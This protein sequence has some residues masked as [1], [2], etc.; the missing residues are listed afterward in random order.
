MQDFGSP[1][2]KSYSI[3]S[4]T[5]VIVILVSQSTIDLEYGLTFNPTT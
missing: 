4:F 1:L 3:V 2:Y 5:S